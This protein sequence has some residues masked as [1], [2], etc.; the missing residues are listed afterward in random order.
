MPHLSLS[1][2]GPPEFRL[3]SRLITAYHSDKVR[4]L[5][6]YLAVETS[7]AHRRRGGE[8]AARGRG[9]GAGTGAG[10][11][12]VGDSEG[13]VGRAGGGSELRPD[14]SQ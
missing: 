7:R 3:T 13:V 8:L 4:A 11:G 14:S 2:L 9:C 10:A 5:L 1:L 6:A 12:P